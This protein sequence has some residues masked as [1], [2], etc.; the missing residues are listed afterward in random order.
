MLGV[1]L[2]FRPILTKFTPGNGSL[3]HCGPS[4]VK[5]TKKNPDLNADVT[6][7]IIG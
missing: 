7:S 1:V 4:K 2:V 3:D 5:L 6:T